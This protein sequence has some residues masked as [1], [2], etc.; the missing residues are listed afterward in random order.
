MQLRVR[1]PQ[2][3]LALPIRGGKRRGAG[4]KPKGARA[5]VSHHGRPKLTL[6]HPAHVTLRVREHVW[7]LRSQR[8]W[9]LIEAALAVCRQRGLMR[10]THVSVQ[11]NHI[12]MIVEAEDNGALARAMKGFQVRLARAL[13]RLMS[14]SGA[15]FADRYHF[16]VLRTPAEVRNA[17]A[18]VLDNFAGHA[19]RRG[20]ALGP[21][22]RD[23]FAMS[24]TVDDS[25]RS[26]T[27]VPLS[28]PQT[29]LLRCASATSTGVEK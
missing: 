15:V 20:E 23:R 19:R 11:G 21:D 16:H 27:G 25:S 7:N 8:C 9:H 5:G 29:W 4:R 13:N 3:E 24:M 26:G 2:L 18:Y 14:R 1:H 6:H 28:A 17:L 12:H 22:W 10:V